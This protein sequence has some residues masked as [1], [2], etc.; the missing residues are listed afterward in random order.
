MKKF[1]ILHYGFVQPTPEDMAGWN[2]WF[3]SIADIQIERGHFPAGREIAESG[4]KDL[5]FGRES[6]TGYT[7]INAESL[8]EAD[9]IAQNCPFV[10]STRVYEVG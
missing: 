5:P 10:D 9:K 7:L 3:E 2:Q 1:L 4:T 8:D 6:I